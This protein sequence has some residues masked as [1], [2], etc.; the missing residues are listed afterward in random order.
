MMP[1]KHRSRQ[2]IKIASAPLT[3]VL[4]PLWL[5]RIP[6]LLGD[7]LR[8]TMRTPHPLRPAQFAH[9]LVT[10]GIINQIL[11]IQHHRGLGSRHSKGAVAYPILQL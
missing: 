7:L 4:L 3:V 10:V 9:R 8:I 5:G 6:S 1:G 11:D 2:I